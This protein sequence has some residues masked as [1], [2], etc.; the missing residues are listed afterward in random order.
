MITSVSYSE[1]K[2]VRLYKAEIFASAYTIGVDLHGRNMLLL[3]F[4]EDQ[5]PLPTFKL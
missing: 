3:P 5:L 1:S 2:K 4:W